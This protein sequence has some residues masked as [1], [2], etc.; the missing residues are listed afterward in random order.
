MTSTLPPPPATRKARA[1]HERLV[2]ATREVVRRSGVLAPE[3]IAEHASV[4]PA[5]FYTY[6]SSKDEALAA[7][8]DAVLAEMRVRL[9]AT[10]GV[11]QV[12]EE[13]LAPVVRRMTHEVV[14]GFA[15]DARLFRLAI[16]RLPD[17]EVI[18]AVYRGREAEA[19]AL[20]ARFVRLSAAA[21][22]VRPADPDTLAA[23]LLVSVQGLQNPLLHRPGAAPVIDEIAAVVVALLAPR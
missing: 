20:L 6:F 3:A 2:A 1:T 13:G 18:R 12:L 10:L 4:S 17:S 15:H 11:E 9:E 22:R 14:R 21:G 23:A 19:L 8:F 5:T 7:A 16:S